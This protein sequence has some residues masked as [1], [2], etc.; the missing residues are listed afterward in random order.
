MGEQGNGT[1]DHIGKLFGHLSLLNI[2]INGNASIKARGLMLVRAWA[3]A[4]DKSNAL[5]SIVNTDV[6]LCVDTYPKCLNSAL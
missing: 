2:E 3:Q 6:G 4:L 5:G 1:N